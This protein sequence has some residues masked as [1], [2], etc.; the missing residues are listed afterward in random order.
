M[1]QVIRPSQQGIVLVKDDVSLQPS[2]DQILNNQP[3]RATGPSSL[4]AEL[5]S[6]TSKTNGTIVD[7]LVDDSHKSIPSSSAIPVGEDI[8]DLF[9]SRSPI[10]DFDSSKDKN[11]FVLNGGNLSQDYHLMHKGQSPNIPG[12]L[13]DMQLNFKP[14][15]TSSSKIHVEDQKQEQAQGFKDQIGAQEKTLRKRD[16]KAHDKHQQQLQQQCQ[17]RVQE[18][19][20]KQKI[21]VT[22][23]VVLP[24]NLHIWVKDTE[25]LNLYEAYVQFGDGKFIEKLNKWVKGRKYQC[26]EHVTDDKLTLKV[27]IFTFQLHHQTNHPQ[28]IWQQQGSTAHSFLLDEVKAVAQ[29]RKDIIKQMKL[30]QYFIF[31]VCPPN[32]ELSKW[33][34]RVPPSQIQKY[35]EDPEHLFIKKE[36]L[37]RREKRDGH[38]QH[39]LIFTEEMC[40]D[41]EPQRYPNIFS[42]KLLIYGSPDFEFQVCPL[43]RRELVTEQEQLIKNEA[44]N[45]HSATE[46]QIIRL[47]GFRY[48]Y[49]VSLGV[50][51]N[52]VYT[53][54]FPKVI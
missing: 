21:N 25:T 5:G 53:V 6:T 47:S 35:V 16:L 45:I 34:S 40:F 30:F 3:G 51:H 41:E 49:N 17:S 18:V 36:A 46:A 8:M 52:E 43:K 13:E 28:K 37:G 12:S 31:N 33:L 26:L 4:Q 7:E 32:S 39:Y 23:E 10:D 54:Y 2:F 1:E 14:T 48:K 11:A 38:W 29:E 42:D 20:E 22:E 27:K 50:R 19:I 44:E 24:E 9:M 15:T